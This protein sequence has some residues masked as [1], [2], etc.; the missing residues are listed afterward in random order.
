[1]SLVKRTIA[2]V[3]AS[4]LL[5]S[6]STQATAAENPLKIVLE[7]AI[8][9]GVIGTLIGAATIAFTDHKS[10]HIDNIGYGAAIG[11]IA[12][13]G[14][15]LY[16]NIDRSLVEYENGKVRIAMPTVI[17]KLQESSSGQMVV[18]FRA[19]LLRGTF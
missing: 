1:M 2:V 11:V 12:G 7:D 6:W 19:D 3:M 10:D 15:G 4:F 18:S 17:P 9:G 13:T 16:T 14:F 5:A 8:Y